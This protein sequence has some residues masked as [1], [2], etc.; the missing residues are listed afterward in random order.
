[1]HVRVGQHCETRPHFEQRPEQADELEGVSVALLGEDEDRLV[2]ERL[3]A[4]F[5]GRY[6]RPP[7]RMQLVGEAG[8]IIVKAGLPVG[9]EEP[10]HAAIVDRLGI[11]PVYRNGAA[12]ALDRLVEACKR[13]QG[14]TAIVE[15]ARVLG[16]ACDHRVIATERFGRPPEIDQHIAPVDDGVDKGRIERD[17]LVEGLE[18]LV[19]AV[20]LLQH[21]AAIVERLREIGL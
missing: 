14:D 7:D 18:R 15:G 11:G 3:A 2:L 5:G 13:A 19:E 9:G 16:L 20:Q 10:G 8:L 1:M 17:R 21:I 12:I 4:P 6:V